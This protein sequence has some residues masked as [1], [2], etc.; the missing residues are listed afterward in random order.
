MSANVWVVP[1][2]FNG[3]ADTRK[4][5]R[6]LAELSPAGVRAPCPT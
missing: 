3:L 4:C 2:N 1:V 5:L 6:S